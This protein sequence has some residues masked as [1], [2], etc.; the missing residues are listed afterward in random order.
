LGKACEVLDETNAKGEYSVA[1]STCEGPYLL[2]AE[3]TLGTIHSI[4]TSA[5]YGKH[6]SITPI[7]ELIAGRVLG[8][9]NLALLDKDHFHA[10]DIS[11]NSINESEAQIKSLLGPLL[12]SQGLANFDLLN[13]AFEA[14][15]DGFD[16]L[17]DAI[18]VSPKTTNQYSFRIKGSEVNV[19]L[20]MDS[21]GEI[22]S[23]EDV[24]KLSDESNLEMVNTSSGVLSEIR[25][26][27]TE[28]NTKLAMEKSEEKNALV[29][30]FFTDDFLHF[31]KSSYQDLFF[32]S[33]DSVIFEN[34][35]ILNL[36]SVNGIADVWVHESH[37]SLFEDEVGS[38][39]IISS[40]SYQMKFK[41]N[42]GVWY[43]HG[44]RIPISLDIYPKYINLNNE[45]FR[46][47][48]VEF[49]ETEK[50]NVKI[51]SDSLSDIVYNSGEAFKSLT[52]PTQK[53]AVS[54]L[55]CQDFINI[56]STSVLPTFLKLSVRVDDQ[57][58]ELYVLAPKSGITKD[59]FAQFTN[60][61]IEGLCGSQDISTFPLDIFFT[62]P[63][64]HNLDKYGYISG[65]ISG[66][67]KFNPTTNS[68][69]YKDKKIS[70]EIL[71]A[72]DQPYSGPLGIE[73]L[74]VQLDSWDE[75]G[76]GYYNIYSCRRN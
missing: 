32:D 3:G 48:S 52:D 12:L 10:T 15:G 55:F 63:S 76:S 62:L 7:T 66:G 54:D 16:K 57:P 8:S 21:G 75:R 59:S 35:V 69:L 74:M 60:I 42:E 26:R 34:P 61:P 41:K 67:L 70:T 37:T 24:N 14:D 1:L 43:F 19:D 40:D 46:G 4:A 44:N 2:R 30:G 68:S 56:T 45:P 18:E 23:D 64:G 20:N 71:G 5:D 28:L 39:T 36:D 9:A 53:C 11:A 65:Q 73:S 72:D 27:L 51:S 13:D 33:W 22:A 25:A 50:Y 6:V 47:L 49:Y 17:L 31:G 58:Y 29:A 38:E